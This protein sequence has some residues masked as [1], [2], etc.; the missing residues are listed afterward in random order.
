VE[1]A[2]HAMSFLKDTD[3]YIAAMEDLFA[4]WE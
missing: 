4:G 3:K 1:E 2:T